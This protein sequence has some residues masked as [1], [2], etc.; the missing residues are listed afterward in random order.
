MET[1][2]RCRRCHR[3]IP[4]GLRGKYRQVNA[5]KTGEWSTGSSTSSG[6]ED[7]RT[8]SLEAENKELRPGMRP[9]RRREEKELKEG[10]TFHPGA[11]EEEWE[12]GHGRGGGD[13]EPQKAG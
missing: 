9:W 8:K 2:W 7:K 13:R 6:E 4:A 1:R 3:D 12:N 5:A 11:T 10:K